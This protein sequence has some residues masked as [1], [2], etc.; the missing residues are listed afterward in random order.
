MTNKRRKNVFVKY[1]GRCYYCGDVLEYED[2]HMDHI[3]PKAKGGRG[4]IENLVPSCCLCNLSKGE[5]TVSEFRTRIENLNSDTRV[6]LFCKYREV[7]YEP[8]V[9]YFERRD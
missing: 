2:F 9:F 6:K 4:I 3:I 1:G 5:L 7:I 8:I